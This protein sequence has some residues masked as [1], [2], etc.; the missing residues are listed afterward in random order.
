LNQNL[1]WSRIKAGTALV[2][3]N[4]R[5]Y[6]PTARAARI[7]IELGGRV[8]TVFDSATNLMAHFPCSIARQAQ[9]RLVG[10]LKVTS[11]APLPHYTFDPDRFP[12]SPESRMATGT[13]QIPPGPNNP[14][15]TVWIGLDQPGYGIHGT[16]HPERIGEAAS[17]GCFRLANWNADLLARL[18]WVGM[19]VEVAP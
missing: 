11:I 15:G 13:L 9:D 4:A 14:V 3:P 16:P 8:L 5:P 6:V 18:A 19:P 2:V 10:L 7:R 12:A 1:D 17:L